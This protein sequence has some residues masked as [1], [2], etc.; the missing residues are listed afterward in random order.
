MQNIA[1][2]VFDV[3]GVIMKERNGNFPVFI[4]EK[5]GRIFDRAEYIKLYRPMSLGAIDFREGMFNFGFDDPDAASYDYILNYVNF[6][7]EFYDFAERCK[8]AGFSL[9]IL[10]ND[11]S[12]WS[13]LMR[14]IYD[15]NKYF[16]KIIISGDVNLR[17]PEPE[18]FELAL[19]KIGA[20]ANKCLYID[21]NLEN[22]ETAGKFN[23][24]TVLFRREGDMPEVINNINY[25]AGS[26]GEL[27]ELIESQ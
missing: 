23:F 14:E 10:S 9:N 19:S 17:K 8:S 2:I 18:I 7:H 25:S 11:V 21:D 4:A 20:E 27:W 15:I 1:T 16:D 6:D 26:F 22:L 12:E 3:Y 13:K 5:T 24:N